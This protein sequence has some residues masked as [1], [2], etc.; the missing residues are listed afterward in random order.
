MNVKS[1]PSEFLTAVGSLAFHLVVFT[2]LSFLVAHREP[3]TRLPQNAIKVSIQDQKPEVPPPPP[4]VQKERK[5]IP[6][7]PPKVAQSAPQK[8]EPKPDTPPPQPVY[9][10]AK[11]SLSPAQ[12]GGIAVPVGN[13]TMMADDGKRMRPEDVQKLDR[14]LSSDPQLE[15][16]SLALP[17]YTD[18]AVEAGL[19]GRFVVDV[20]VNE[21]GA[22]DDVQ[23]RKKIGFEM[24][25]RVMEAIRKARFKPRRNPVG[26]P[27]AGWTEITIRLELD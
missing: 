4:P 22:V 27:I 14:D 10:V 13:T 6:P 3:R 11:E 8:M 24:D 1:V 25:T 12:Q 23:L 5:K 17:K 15:L 26:L 20:Y 21:R 7:K 2:G 16:N 19:E 18:A 9:G